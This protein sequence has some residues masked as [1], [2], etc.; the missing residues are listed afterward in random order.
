MLYQLYVTVY[1]ARHTLFA[2]TE[3][4]GFKP[5]IDD[6]WIC[7]TEENEVQMINIS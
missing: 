6:S 1:F 3:S 5:A 7:E 2:F 4:L